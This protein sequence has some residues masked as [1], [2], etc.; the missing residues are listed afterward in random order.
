MKKIKFKNFILAATVLFASGLS[1]LN[2]NAATQTRSMHVSPPN[3]RMILIPGEKY[4]DSLVVSNANDSTRDLKY[5]LSI[6][7]FSENGGENSKDDYG[8]VDHISISSYNQIMNW[9][10]LDR[11]GGTVAPNGKEVVSYTINVPENAP[12]GGQYATILVKDVTDK[13]APSDGNIKIGNTLQFGHIIY[14]EVAG[15]T[16]QEGSILENNVPTFIF[17][18]PLTVSS[19][20][21]NKGNVHTDAEYTLEITPLFSNE[22][23]YTN[24]EEPRTSLILPE[25]KRYVAQTWDDAPMFGIFKVKQTVKLFGDVSTVEK[26]VIICPLWLLLVIVFVVVAVVVWLITRSKSRKKRKYTEE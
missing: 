22:E 19:M 24:A 6:G 18:T 2:T 10:T 26:T 5:E 4:T 14:A 7:S 25:T 17:S 20:V 9:I 13:D 12:A 16:K 1:T 11:E 3:Q 21:E 23:V 15:E 8:T